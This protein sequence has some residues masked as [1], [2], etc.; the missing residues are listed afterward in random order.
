VKKA[1]RLA[2]ISLIIILFATSGIYVYN[3]FIKSY[4][5]CSF[6]AQSTCVKPDQGTN[7]TITITPHH[8][9]SFTSNSNPQSIKIYYIGNQSLTYNNIQCYRE[10]AF[11]E[12][13]NSTKNY[14]QL[15]GVTP[16]CT[17]IPVKKIKGN[18]ETSISVKWNGTIIEYP[19]NLTTRPVYEPAIPGNYAMVPELYICGVGNTELFAKNVQLINY[20][21][22]VK[23]MQ[24]VNKSKKDKVSEEG[25]CIGTLKNSVAH[26]SILSSYYNISCKKVYKMTYDNFTIGCNQ[27]VT[28]NTLNSTELDEP[29]YNNIRIFTEI[30]VILDNLTFKWSDESFF[31][32]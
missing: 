7:F 3:S 22:H 14:R 13:Y 16:L 8:G 2:I 10:N 30:K 9:A 24:L 18:T 26:V 32:E 23:G 12:K 20:I 21:I 27:T 5:D 6:S 11:V 19:G 29:T 4:Y 28:L 17:S 25:Y 1:L 31:I 15:N